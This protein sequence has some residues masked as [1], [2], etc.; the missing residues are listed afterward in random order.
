MQWLLVLLQVLL[1]LREHKV[2]QALC[3]APRRPPPPPA[4]VAALSAASLIFFAFLVS[5]GITLPGASLRAKRPRT[6]G[7]V[8][9]SDLRHWY[10]ILRLKLRS[11]RFSR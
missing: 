1:L 2:L 5:C 8:S 11:C 3:R 6:L 9:A 4:A 10:L 7:R